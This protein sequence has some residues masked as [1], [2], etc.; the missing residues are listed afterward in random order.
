MR[1]NGGFRGPRT[2]LLH[3]ASDLSRSFL[4]LPRPLCWFPGWNRLFGLFTGRF[5]FKTF[6]ASMSSLRLPSGL[7]DLVLARTSTS[8]N[9]GSRAHAP[10]RHALSTRNAHSPAM[11]KPRITPAV[12]TVPPA[13]RDFY[14]RC[15]PCLCSYASVTQLCLRLKR[16]TSKK[17]ET[18]VAPLDNPSPRPT[19]ALAERIGAL[20]EAVALPEVR[21]HLRFTS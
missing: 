1:V 18:A 11:L 7:I 12:D 9:S 3:A 10:L 19:S 15:V 2:K 14:A 13:E 20:R 16:R 6:P 5:A 4:H 17:N 8:T 21:P